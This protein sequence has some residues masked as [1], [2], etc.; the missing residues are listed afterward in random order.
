MRNDAP[1][2]WRHARRNIH[3]TENFTGHIAGRVGMKSALS[4]AASGT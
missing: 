2:P 4:G 1:P 3:A